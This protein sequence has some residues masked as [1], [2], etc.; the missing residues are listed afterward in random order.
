MR[1]RLPLLAAFLLAA[2]SVRAQVPILHEPLPASPPGYGPT[3]G[4]EDG[5]EDLDAAAT[6]ADEGLG[7]REEGL[8]AGR[9]PSGLPPEGLPRLSPPGA[10]RLD[11]QTGHDPVLTYFAV[12]DPWPPGLF[13]QQL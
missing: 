3:A 11:G 13:A 4:S 8:Y 12:F 10:V 9:I 7:A 6:G 2:A 5:A 1:I